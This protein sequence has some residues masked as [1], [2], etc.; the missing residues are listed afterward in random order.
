MESGMELERTTTYPGRCDEPDKSEDARWIEICREGDLTAFERLVQKY[1]RLA[2]WIAF[3]MVGNREDAKDIS[4]E[5]FIR[6]YRSLGRFNPRYRFSSYL[7]RIVMNVSIDHLR[8]RRTRNWDRLP[9]G[10]GEAKPP[11]QPWRALDRKIRA[12]LVRGMVARL[13]GKYRSVIVL[14]DLHGLSFDEVGRILRCGNA[15][16]RWRLH[17]ARKMLRERIEK[18]I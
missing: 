9:P 15:T 7:I 4:Q 1:R 3:D 12:E 18:Y 5:A 6:I 8:R 13:P 10:A 17:Q 16:L 14:R 11:L 2:Y